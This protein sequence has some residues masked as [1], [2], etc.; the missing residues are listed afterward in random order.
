MKNFALVLIVIASMLFSCQPAEIPS[1]EG[2]DDTPPTETTPQLQ[3]LVY[4]PTT[5]GAKAVVSNAGNDSKVDIPLTV[6]PKAY[7][8]TLSKNWKKTTSCQA[9]YSD[10]SSAPISLPIIGYKANTQSGII[11]LTALGSGLSEAFFDGSQAASAQVSISDGDNLILSDIIPLEA[12]EFEDPDKYGGWQKYPKWN[13]IKVMSFNVRLDTSESDATNNW[14]NRK[15]ACIDLIKD[16]QPC[17]IGFQEAKYTSQ[18]LYIKEQLK[19]DYDGW[20]VNRDTGKTSGSGEVMGILYNKSKVE[21]IDG[22]TFWLSETPDKCSQGWDAACY[23]TAT[24]GTF[25]HLATNRQFIYVNTHLDHKGTEARVKGLELIAK[26]FNEHS[27]CTP[28]LTGD[29]NIASTHEA[30]K[31]ITGTMKNTRDHAP[32]NHTDQTTTYN[33][34]KQTNN[35]IIDHIYCHKTLVV[36]EYHTI[37]EDYGVPYV[38]DHYPIYSIIQLQ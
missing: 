3:S 22:G 31:V 36:S 6:T 27:S 5:A 10:D 20:G 34:Y 4:T 2:A 16:H 28:I 23:R 19:E 12:G 35:S 8:A 13:E 1:N 24:W 7:L 11:T 9:S 37:N 26:F 32:A 18:W 30:F 21:K 29:M 38:S 33:A 15:E 17:I 14:S 25:K